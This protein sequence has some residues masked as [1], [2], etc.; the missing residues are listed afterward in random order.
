MNAE[1]ALSARVRQIAADL[2]S[3]GSVD[4]EPQAILAAIHV[5]VAADRLPSR[6]AGGGASLPD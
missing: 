1:T 5:I 2:L 6:R 4:D 3:D